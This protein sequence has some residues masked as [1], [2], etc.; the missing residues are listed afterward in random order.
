M[1]VTEETI[2]LYL[3]GAGPG[4]NIVLP[5]DEGI[6]SELLGKLREYLANETM[7]APANAGALRRMLAT[8]AAANAWSD[9]LYGAPIQT[10]D[11]LTR[12]KLRRELWTLA[13]SGVMFYPDKEKERMELLERIRE[14]EE[15]D[16]PP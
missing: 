2:P 9:A 5:E 4:G 8:A 13:Y 15:I 11:R 14:L 6:L 12:A 3:L 7:R 16:F 10:R 1:E